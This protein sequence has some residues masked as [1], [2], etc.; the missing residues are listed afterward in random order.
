MDEIKRFLKTTPDSLF[1]LWSHTFWK[2][3]RGEQEH[4]VSQAC[5]KG[6]MP[7]MESLGLFWRLQNIQASNGFGWC[8]GSKGNEGTKIWALEGVIKNVTATVMNLK[9]G[10]CLRC[11]MKW[12]DF[13][14]VVPL[15]MGL[16]ISGV[17]GLWDLTWGCKAGNQPCHDKFCRVQYVTVVILRRILQHQFFWPPLHKFLYLQDLSMPE[18]CLSSPCPCSELIRAWLC[19]QLRDSQCS[20]TAWDTSP[21]S[22]PPTHSWLKVNTCR[23]P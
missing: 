12:K 13:I 10:T 4:W 21:W 2:P 15:R 8:T 3:P 20:D 17:E 1:W 14:S 16:L 23:A 7:A 11:L 18:L 19:Y 9:F 5:C 22:S 6:K